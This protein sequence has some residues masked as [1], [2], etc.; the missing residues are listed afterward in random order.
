MDLALPAVELVRDVEQAEGVEEAPPRAAQR[1]GEVG[2]AGEQEEG[3]RAGFALVDGA[4]HRGLG[5]GQ[6]AGDAVGVRQLGPGAGA[7][8]RGGR[9]GLAVD[10]R[11]RP[12]RE[13]REVDHLGGLVEPLPARL[14]VGGARRR[15]GEGRIA[16]LRQ[17]RLGG[18]GDLGVGA[19]ENRREGGVDRALVGRIFF[20]VGRSG[21][22]R[23]ERQAG[24]IT[25]RPE[26]R[27]RER[28]HHVLAAQA[29]TQQVGDDPFG[30]GSRQSA[31]EKPRERL[32]SG[33]LFHDVQLHD[34][35]PPPVPNSPT[36]EATARAV[37]SFPK[38]VFLPL[39]QF[40]AQCVPLGSYPAPSSVVGGG[41]AV[42]GAVPPL[43]S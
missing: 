32:A 1:A 19:G 5:R 8:V 24:G 9:S 38:R 28:R 12:H 27:Q 6:V 39:P 16:G 23:S 41:T 43:G 11:G 25:A 21:R 4:C 35:L 3:A 17:A 15:R 33:V 2:D 37:I 30:L 34:P 22:R 31:V 14:Q 40:N 7:Q 18:L 36:F 29:A 10:R 26:Q 13:S 20:H 42:C